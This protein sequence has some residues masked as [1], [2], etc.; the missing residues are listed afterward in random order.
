MGMVLALHSEI[1]Q[2][3]QVSM[4]LASF[5]DKTKSTYGHIIASLQ[6]LQESLPWE[7]V[8][9]RLLQEYEEQISRTGSVSGARS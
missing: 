1:S 4:L 9:V 2:K 3:M 6:S 5:G 7:I 8:T